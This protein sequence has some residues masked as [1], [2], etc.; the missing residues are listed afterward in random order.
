M[1]RDAFKRELENEINNLER[2]GGEIS[3]LLAIMNDTPDFIG[4]RAAG[5]I[6]HDFYCAVERTF[7]N[8]RNCKYI[9]QHRSRMNVMKDRCFKAG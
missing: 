9:I 1:D 6:V 5:S 7:G 4:T 8:L 3:S 2:L